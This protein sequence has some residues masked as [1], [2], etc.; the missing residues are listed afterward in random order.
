[1][2]MRLS[3][4]L[5][6]LFV[7][8]LIFVP[9]LAQAQTKPAKTD[10]GEEDPAKTEA[11]FQAKIKAYYDDWNTL[12]LE[13]A[14]AYYAKDADLVFYDITPLKY[15]GWEAYGAGVQKLLAAYK[16]FHL[17]PQNDLKITRRGKI[18]WTTI[19]CHFSGVLKDGT[20][21]ELEG[22]HTAIWEKR[23]KGDWLIVHEHVSVPLPET[24]ANAPK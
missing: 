9:A 14:G 22:R 20:K 21:A 1:M 8:S 13:K 17:I 10:K 18:V 11:F 15:T 6:Y 12:N 3:R 4:S 7:A 19:G 23:G 24:P 16:T 2:T 5:L